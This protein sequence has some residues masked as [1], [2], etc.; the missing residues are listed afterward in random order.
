MLN[1]KN[2]KLATG[3][4][5]LVFL[6]ACNSSQILKPDNNPEQDILP[7]DKVQIDTSVTDNS[8]LPKRPDYKAM[9]TDKSKWYEALD[10]SKNKLVHMLVKEGD[11][12]S[13]RYLYEN[14]YKSD[15]VN[16]FR[17]SAFMSLADNWW[18]Y[19]QTTKSELL[20]I[21][22]DYNID[23]NMSNNMGV[24]PLMVAIERGYDDLY[25]YLI[26]NGDNVTV[27]SLDRNG[28]KVYPVLRAAAS[29]SV[30]GLKRTIT[31]PSDLYI[32]D[33]EG[34]NV[35]DMILSGIDR[36]K[37]HLDKLELI[38]SYGYEI[39]EHVNSKPAALIE[40]FDISYNQGEVV[41][42]NDLYFKGV[43]KNYLN[44]IK[45][46]DQNG[47]EVKSLNHPVTRENLAHKAA[48]F[49]N[50]ELLTYL[51]SK[52]VNF[53]ASNDQGATALDYA[54][55]YRA[56][57][58]QKFLRQRGVSSLLESVVKE[59]INKNIDNLVAQY[60]SGNVRH[61]RVMSSQEIQD[62]YSMFPTLKAPNYQ[63]S[64]RPVVVI[65]GV[66]N[67]KSAAIKHL[68]DTVDVV[69]G[70]IHKLSSGSSN[71][72]LMGFKTNPTNREDLYI[73]ARWSNDPTLLMIGFYEN[74]NPVSGNVIGS[75]SVNHTF[76]WFTKESLRE[77]YQ[78]YG[79]ARISTKEDYFLKLNPVIHLSN[80]NNGESSCTKV[81]IADKVETCFKGPRVFRYSSGAVHV[82]AAEK[83]PDGSWLVHRYSDHKPTYCAALPYEGKDDL[84]LGT[85]F[86]APASAAIE[87][88]LTR[89][90]GRS[91]G[92]KS[93]VIHE[94]ILLAL[95]M[96]AD[97]DI[98][99]QRSGLKLT[100]N[101]NAAGIGFSKRCGPGV[102]NAQKASLILEQMVLAT[103][104]GL[105]SPTE[106]KLHNVNMNTSRPGKIAAKHIA[107]KGQEY[108]YELTVPEDG[109]I[110]RPY[111]LLEFEYEN[112]GSA[113]FKSPR[114][115]LSFVRP[116]IA[117]HTDTD[118]FIGEFWRKG[119][120]MQIITTK[121]LKIKDDMRTI[122][123]M[124][125]PDSAFAYAI[126]GRNNQLIATKQPIGNKR[127]L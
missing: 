105:A 121:P 51:E 19:D 104:S 115:T 61:P 47:A 82:G 99:D 108:I 68:D 27:P 126:E 41:A 56:T 100:F 14:G 69:N 93:G 28:N 40:S 55:I 48:A 15:T 125:A 6:A 18:H 119:E 70:T 113:V 122:I 44:A 9:I 12:T 58:A 34:R 50:V 53:L 78:K 87:A 71:T 77:Y 37:R 84:F 97:K 52:G 114:G 76:E 120:K 106:I 20:K 118:E 4:L 16:Q 72:K 54:I 94:D 96:S 31:D 29:A 67:Q 101:K 91:S 39:G 32:E 81:D 80:G 112:K 89:L 42:S 5:T 103:R 7:D 21:M 45:Y 116:S 59:D 23:Y 17:Q 65:T 88:E 57:E 35:A 117:G 24:R 36:G 95:Q 63:N 11:S 1:K 79:G 83:L 110:T 111:A 30:S 46:L 66:T 86:S 22:K 2:I 25:N 73:R 107:G 3:A 75:H 102:I 85:S 64:R 10:E 123:R 33:H 60:A 49:N 38:K 43:N 62:N 8:N 90:H 98:T 127:T 109:Y 92:L 74:K 26:K 124:A 13:L